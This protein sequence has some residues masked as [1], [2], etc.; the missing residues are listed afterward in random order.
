MAKV[1]IGNRPTDITKEGK[2]IKVV[3]HP[4]MKNAKHPNAVVFSIVLTEADL[5]ALQKAF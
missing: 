2:S 3:F 5:D 4:I 1:T